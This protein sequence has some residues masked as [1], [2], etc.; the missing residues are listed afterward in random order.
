MTGNDI[1]NTS[2]QLLGYN[3]SNGNTHLTTVIRNR[4]VAIVNL[5]YMELSRNCGVNNTP[6]CSLGDE[7]KLP[8]RVLNEIMPSGV[9]MYIANGEGD[10]NNEAFWG[11]EYNAKRATLSSF[12]TVK[13]TIPKVW[14]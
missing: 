2:L 13:D 10:A 6:I 12:E 11:R 1:L 4:A 14:G 7:I 9:A 3:E 8:D 5:V